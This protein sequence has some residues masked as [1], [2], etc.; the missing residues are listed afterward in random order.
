MKHCFKPRFIVID[1]FSQANEYFRFVSL[2]TAS[3]NEYN[4]WQES[5]K[6]QSREMILLRKEIIAGFQLQLDARQR[7]SD[8]HGYEG[9]FSHEVFDPRGTG[10]HMHLKHNVAKKPS[11]VA[12]LQAKCGERNG[13]TKMSDSSESLSGKIMHVMLNTSLRL[14]SLSE[15]ARSLA[16]CSVYF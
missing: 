16:G 15:Q 7:A 2:F 3:L 6:R 5:S 1:S 13:L 8:W 10:F 12:S 4:S 9:G 14:F 11:R